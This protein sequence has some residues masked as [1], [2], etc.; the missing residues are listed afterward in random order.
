MDEEY[1]K[2]EDAYESLL[3]GMVMTGYQSRAL[4]CISKFSIPAADVAPVRHGRWIK[5]FYYR[6]STQ[7]YDCE[8]YSCSE[9]GNEFSYDA[10]TGMCMCNWGFCPCCGAKMDGGDTNG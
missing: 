10:E 6:Q 3:Y 4:D 9:C 7:A 5:K 1:I 8:M 2:R